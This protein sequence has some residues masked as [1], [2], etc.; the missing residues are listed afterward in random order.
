MGTISDEN[1]NQAAL[2]VANFDECASD[3]LTFGIKL[4]PSQH[5]CAG[6]SHGGVD[7]CQGDSGGPFVCNNLE[8]SGVV[9][10]GI[11]CAAADTYGIY[12]SLAF[13]VDWIAS[14]V[15]CPIG[16]S[17][18][19]CEDDLDECIAGLHNCDA[20]SLCKNLVGSF[21]CIKSVCTTGFEMVNNTC[22]DI[23]ECQMN[24]CH[25][26]MCQNLPG[27]FKCYC[28]TGFDMVGSKCEDRDEC[29]SDPNQCPMDATCFNNP[30]S[31]SCRC[32]EG[33][34]VVNGVCSDPD[35]C[36]R[37]SENSYCL[38][39]KCFCL[40]GWTGDGV[41]C[42]RMQAKCF[43]YYIIKLYTVVLYD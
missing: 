18:S 32:K 23:D 5:L 9:S 27:S 33:L 12:T 11:G 31:F 40:P 6:F 2:P 21:E 24:M 38:E 28:D 37:C 42:D 25:L 39:D 30:G 15:G 41:I 10:F 20:G 1:L 34:T 17:G 16:Y 26:T 35:P 14:E 7:A 43:I 19:N 22:V 8:L 36:S 4:D 29:A 3:Y 13:Y